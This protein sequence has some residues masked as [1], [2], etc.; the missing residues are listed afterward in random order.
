MAQQLSLDDVRRAWSA[1]DP[2]LANLLIALCAASD[3]RPK[4][5][6]PEGVPTFQSFAADLRGWRFRYKSPQVRARFRID[7]MRALEAQQETVPMPSRLGAHAVLLDLWGQAQQPGGAYERQMLLTAIAGVALRFGPWRGLKR[8][9]KEA[10]ECG[11]TEI[12]GALSARFDAQLAASTGSAV[13]SAAGVSE[14]SRHTL[15][16]LCRRAWRALRR[17]AE[18]LPAS[19][20]D[21]AVDFLRFYPENTRWKH[22]WVFNHLLYHE[23]GKFNRR[24]FYFGWRDRNLNALKLRAYPELWRRSPRPLFTLLERANSEQVRDYATKALTSDFRAMLRDVEPSWVTRLV[25]VESATIDRFVIWLLGNVPRFEQSAFRDLGLHEGVLRLLD[26][27]ADEARIYA[28]DYVRTH[29]RDLPLG[30]LIL[31]ANNSN[32]AVRKL[33]GDLLSD[34]DPRKEVGL[35]AWG[36]L[37]GTEHGHELAVTA[38][39]K[40]F[41]ARELS[42]EWFSALFLDSRDRVVGFAAELLPKVHTYKALGADYF[43]RLLDAPEIGR[44]ATDFALDAA[45]RYAVGDYPADFWRRLLLRPHSRSTMIQWIREDKVKADALGAEFWRALAFHP[46]WEADPWAEELRTKGPTW[47]RDLSFD[48]ALADLAFEL[49]GD[50]RKFTP[51]KLGFDWLM[52]LVQRTEP[53]YH[54]FATEYMIKAF[55]PADFAPAGGKDESDAEETTEGGDAVDLGGKSFLFTGKLKTMKRAEA[56]KKVTTA[57]GANASSVTAKLDFLVIGDEGSALYGEGRKGSKQVAGEKLIAKGAAIKIISETAFLQMLAGGERE[58]SEDAVEAGCA[59]LWQMATEPGSD[60]APL[61][62][63]ARLYVRRHHPDISLKLTDRPVD[64]GAE[65]PAEFLSWQRMAPLFAEPRQVLREFAIEFGRWEFGRWSPPIFELVA[66]AEGPH[67][68]VRAFIEEALLA[69]PDDVDSRRFRI[70]PAQLSGDAVYAFCESLQAQ[71]RALGMELIR[72]HPH[73]ASPEELF[74]LSESPDRQVCAFVVRTLW[75]LYRDRGTTEGWV[76]PAA[77]LRRGIENEEQSQGGG[78]P[79]KPEKLPASHQALRDF[80]RRMLFTVPPAKLPAASGEERARARDSRQR[81][82]SARRAKLALVEVLRDLAIE[83]HAF[84]LLV[85]PLLHEFM[86]SRGASERAACLVALVRIAKAHADL[87]LLTNK[88]KEVA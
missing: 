16:Y 33:A 82:L 52:V 45:S 78:S 53:R 67:A 68:E 85:A 19:Y 73:L 54:D 31:L 59:R 10:E 6:I 21:A 1:R 69:D 24:R 88:N 83:E 46:G 87:D 71:A 60:D 23:S 14:V 22:T 2:E 75:S 80:M 17:R 86:G 11:D 55:V 13:R 61:A 49:L 41:G 7:T 66:L 58:F 37:L 5:A 56:K 30:R 79:V 38:L 50:V 48:E 26:S 25:A 63:F 70:D 4:S 62:R 15:A 36:R 35:D 3:E 40:H 51:D 28:A 84:A 27:A 39:R 42:P 65:M 57:G 29:A 81:P 47:A 64:P 8:I 77:P 20:A 34:R 12:L 32:A 74:R 9:F 76:P 43:R 18:G 44:R 72:R